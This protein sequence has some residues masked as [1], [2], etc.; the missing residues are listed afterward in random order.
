MNLVEVNDSIAQLVLPTEFNQWIL[1]LLSD[2]ET[3][4]L[5][6][7]LHLWKY[8][9]RICSIVSHLDP[10]FIMLLYDNSRLFKL[11]NLILKELKETDGENSKKLM[12]SILRQWLML[13]LTCLDI[14]MCLQRRKASIPYSNQFYQI[15]YLLRVYPRDHTQL[16]QH[17]TTTT[18]TVGDDNDKFTAL[19]SYRENLIRKIKAGSILPRIFY[20][21]NPDDINFSTFL[22]QYIKFCSLHL[23]RGL[24]GQSSTE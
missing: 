9:T 20:D 4:I 13:F 8:F 22:N 21:F 11:V 19:T 16:L 1:S 12:Q 5:S 15:Q 18:A 10:D 24:C 17:N 2:T 3:L 14:R 6:N 23:Y 7:D